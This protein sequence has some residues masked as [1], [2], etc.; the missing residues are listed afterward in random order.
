MWHFA[1]TWFQEFPDYHPNDD[2]ISIFTESVSPCSLL[3]L[4]VRR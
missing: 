1:Q 3:E 2:K 4:N